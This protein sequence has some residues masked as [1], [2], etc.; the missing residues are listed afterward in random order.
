MNLGESVTVS[1][2]FQ[3]RRG[4]RNTF[5]K[6]NPFV[7]NLIDIGVALLTLKLFGES[8]GPLL[9]QVFFHW[10]LIR[11]RVQLEKFWLR[12]HKGFAFLLWDQMQFWLDQVALHLTRVV[13]VKSKSF[14]RF[15]NLFVNQVF[16]GKLILNWWFYFYL[17][18]VK[19]L[20]KC[21][22]PSLIYNLPGA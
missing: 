21:F 10:V 17:S 4:S 12:L 1:F 14:V 20:N 3:V 22:P 9:V 8:Q 13:V 19:R 6:F 5:F 16:D 7:K 2:F 15:P 18:V 11:P